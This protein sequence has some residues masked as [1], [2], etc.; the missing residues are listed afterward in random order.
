[1][2]TPLHHRHEGVPSMPEVLWWL[3]WCAGVWL[4][5]GGLVGWW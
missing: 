4:L 2:L 5:I 3:V 1:M